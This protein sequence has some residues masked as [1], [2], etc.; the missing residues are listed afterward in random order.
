MNTNYLFSTGGNPTLTPRHNPPIPTPPNKNPPSQSPSSQSPSKTRPTKTRT[1]R[2]SGVHV[3]VRGEDTSVRRLEGHQGNPGVAGSKA[4]G[5]RVPVTRS[6][7]LKKNKTI[8][9]FPRAAIWATVIHDLCFPA[10]EIPALTS[11][12]PESWR[13]PFEWRFKGKPAPKPPAGPKDPGKK[14]RSRQPGFSG[15]FRVL[16]LLLT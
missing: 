2:L 16:F 8:G 5:A 6:I 3:P 4:P 10:V 7:C 1:T 15:I 11:G 14:R 13:P 9:Q 12:D